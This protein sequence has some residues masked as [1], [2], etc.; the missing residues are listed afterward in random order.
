M[1]HAGHGFVVQARKSSSTSTLN[2][3]LRKRKHCDINFFVE[4]SIYLDLVIINNCDSF[5]G[6]PNIEYP[7]IAANRHLSVDVCHRSEIALA[8][9]ERSPFA[10]VPRLRI[11]NGKRFPGPL[12]CV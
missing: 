2:L 10:S 5:I 4:K 12:K 8:H 9:Q 6:D 11:S 7:T 1:W 3:S